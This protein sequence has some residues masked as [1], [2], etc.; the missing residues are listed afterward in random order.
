MT[1]SPNTPRLAPAAPGTAWSATGATFDV[2]GYVTLSG[3][4][5]ANSAFRVEYA[6]T[7]FADNVID[8]YVSAEGSLIGAALLC[9]YDLQFDAIKRSRWM[10][11]NGSQFDDTNGA[12]VVDGIIAR[13]EKQQAQEAMGAGGFWSWAEEQA[14]T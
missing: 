8:E 13:L 11:A 7:V 5:S 14:N 4:I 3:I 1:T 9:A 6:H 12:K 2:T 10:A